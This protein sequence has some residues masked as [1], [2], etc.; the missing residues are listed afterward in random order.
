VGSVVIVSLGVSV[1][2]L[3]EKCEEGRGVLEGLI[4]DLAG[5]GVQANEGEG[6]E[7]LLELRLNMLK[8]FIYCSFL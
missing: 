5:E 6:K 3:I 4:Q 2:W 7:K 8:V 1:D